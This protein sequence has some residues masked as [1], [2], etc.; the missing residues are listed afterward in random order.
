[1]VWGGQLYLGGGYNMTKSGETGAWRV[2][3]AGARVSHRVQDV[4]GSD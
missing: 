2:E 3:K 4:G 1:M